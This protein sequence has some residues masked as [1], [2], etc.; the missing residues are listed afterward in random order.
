MNIQSCSTVCFGSIM[1]KF[2]IGA[3]FN[4]CLKYVQ[5]ILK[6]TIIGAVFT[7]CLKNIESIMKQIII[8]AVLL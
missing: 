2:L 4:L 3:V 8:G 6:K 5:C 7:K 1:K